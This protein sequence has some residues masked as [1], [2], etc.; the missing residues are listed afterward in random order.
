MWEDGQPCTAD[1]NTAPPDGSV[2]EAVLPTSSQ[3]RR[4]ESDDTFPRGVGVSLF[5]EGRL[6]W[7]SGGHEGASETTDPASR[8]AWTGTGQH[9][10]PA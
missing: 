9:Q 6:C 4:P 8:G 3:E 5:R 2:K 7:G 10:R 1:A